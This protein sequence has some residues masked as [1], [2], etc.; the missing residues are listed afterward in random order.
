MPRN[1][2]F[3]Q[4]IN[5]FSKFIHETIFLKLEYCGQN[6]VSGLH[7]KKSG[8]IFF[9]PKLLDAK[10]SVRCRKFTFLLQQEFKEQSTVTGYGIGRKTS[11]QSFGKRT[12]Q[13]TKMETDWYEKPQ[14]RL[15]RRLLM[16]KNG[17][18]SD[19]TTRWQHLQVLRED[20]SFFRF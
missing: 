9:Q 2:I 10:H 13:E 12:K 3:F 14:L 19:L 5:D 6:E 1:A 18:I 16:V 17:H 15:S 8:V 11:R 4:E 20:K 7:P